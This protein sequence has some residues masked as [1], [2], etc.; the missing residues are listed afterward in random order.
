MKTRR[1][2]SSRVVTALAIAGVVGPILFWALLLLAQSLHP[3]YDAWEDST[4]RLIFG[5]FGWLQT[6]NFYLI[7]LF[8][9][10]FGA[11][12]YLGIAKS[13]I[14]RIA[15]LLLVVM[16]FAQLLTAVFPVDVDPFGPKS[17]A[18]IIH[19]LAFIV[20]AASF[21][22]GAFMLVPNLWSDAR[23]RPF[24]YL[25]LAAATVVLILGLV[26]LVSRPIE[27]HLIDSWFGVYERILFSIPL[28]WMIVI[29]TRLLYLGH[30]P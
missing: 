11:A 29:S 13:R 18:Y 25:T 16:G 2:K 12:V 23:W 21:P 24:A 17:M 22:F 4:S 20:S 1:A 15:S 6:M 30:R 5:P 7:A 3:G 8:I 19:N 26:W 27:P 28:A 9:A 14:A 10:A